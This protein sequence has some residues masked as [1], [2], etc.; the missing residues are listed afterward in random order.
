MYVKYFIT[1][2]PLKT[3]DTSF[4]MGLLISVISGDL[5]HDCLKDFINVVNSI[6]YFNL[7]SDLKRLDSFSKLKSQINFLN[8]EF[9]L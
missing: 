3:N 2:I 1:G 8:E 7:L 5:A 9:L 6:F 4:F